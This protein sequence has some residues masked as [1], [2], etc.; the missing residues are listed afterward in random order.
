MP[1]DLNPYAAPP[2]LPAAAVDPVD[3]AR[4]RIRNQVGPPSIGLMVLGGMMCPYVLACLGIPFYAFAAVADSLVRYP[5][6]D[7]P[8]EA[9]FNLLQL[10][11]ATLLGIQQ[12]L[13]FRGSLHLRYLGSYRWARA[14]AWLALIPQPM[15]P[16][17][18]PFAIW[19]LIVLRKPD[20][21]AAFKLSQ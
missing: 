5:G 17:E 15:W 6:M 9:Q 20:V 3:A 12:A 4:K 2:P 19:A 8:T 11:L 16:F 1:S 10:V 7:F 13:I 21:R 14:A 18:A